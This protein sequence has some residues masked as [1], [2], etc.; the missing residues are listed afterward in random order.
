MQNFAD[1]KREEKTM[2]MAGRK[3]IALKCESCGHEDAVFFR[4]LNGTSPLKEM[5][6]R[7]KGKKCPECGERMKEDKKTRIVF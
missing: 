6:F 3:G 4:T 7:L 2:V 1:E 5:V